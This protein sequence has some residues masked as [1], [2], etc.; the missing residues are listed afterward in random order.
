M[1]LCLI[2]PIKYI[3][4][5]KL[6]PGRFCLGHIAMENEVYGRAF[7]EDGKKG[8]KV[9]LDNGVF[10][11]EVIHEADYVELAH[12]IEP[13][14]LVIPDILNGAA[15]VNLKHAIKFATKYKDTLS[16]CNFMFVPQCRPQDDEGFE[17][18][19]RDAIA[20]G[21]FKYIGICRN[22]THSAFSQYT[23]IENEDVNKFYFGV[24]AERLGIFEA[25]REKNV[26]FHILGV[27]IDYGMLSYC[28]WADSADSA[29][30]FYQSAE[31]RLMYSGHLDPG[32]HR[33][34]DYFIRDYE[35]EDAWIETLRIN[36]RRAARHASDAL[37][38]KRYIM[39]GKI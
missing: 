21:L 4:Y 6:L 3:E 36:C 18:A 5:R 31:S 29:G 35:P 28:W 1:D 38:L 25:A 17:K 16:C 9:I 26:K 10:E 20:S 30:L 2:T 34:S 23:H 8:Y 19:L 11:E 39:G 13:S 15:D 33:P 14:I 37:K 22:A 27:G 32:I 7:E 12:E 24:W